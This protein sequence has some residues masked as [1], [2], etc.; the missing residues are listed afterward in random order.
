TLLRSMQQI[1]PPTP[2]VEQGRLIGQF[3]GFDTIISIDCDKF[4]NQWYPHIAYHRDQMEFP[5]IHPAM[6]TRLGPMRLCFGINGGMRHFSFSFSFSC[7]PMLLVPHSSSGFQSRAVSSYRSP[8]GGP[9]LNK[10]ATRWQ[11]KAPI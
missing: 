3:G 8:T 9:G 10:R 7:F 5:P 2:P 1:P 11:P 6:P 4:G